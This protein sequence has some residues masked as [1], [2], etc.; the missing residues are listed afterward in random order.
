MKLFEVI[1]STVPQ[2]GESS[3]EAKT[4]RPDAKI[5][6]KNLTVAEILSTVEGIPYV[7]EVLQDYDKNDFSWGVTKKAVEYANYLKNN[8]ATV[9]NLP[10]IVVIDGS[11]D[12]GAH[13]LSAINL[14]Q[15]R[16]DP[17]NP[18]WNRVKLRVNFASKSDIL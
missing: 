12:D 5:K 4:F 9:K 7:N 14:L 2:P 16:L 1:Q 15:K 10:A 11:L 6:T 18:L 8:P 17:K 3:G 13:R